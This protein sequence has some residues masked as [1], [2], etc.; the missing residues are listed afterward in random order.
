MKQ[1]KKKRG[2]EMQKNNSKKTHNDRVSNSGQLLEKLTS[3]T[4]TPSTQTHYIASKMLYLNQFPWGIK[5]L[6]K[7]KRYLQKKK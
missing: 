5:F 7:I 3:F 4:T 2:K 6:I 1:K